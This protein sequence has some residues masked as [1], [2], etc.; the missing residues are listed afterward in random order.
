[1]TTT[2]PL[3]QFLT[4]IWFLPLFLVLPVL[5]ISIIVATRNGEGTRGDT[6]FVAT[7]GEI[8]TP[9]QP[10]KRIVPPPTQLSGS[11]MVDGPF[12][13]SE[14]QDGVVHRLPKWIQQY[15]TWHKQMRSL[16]PGKMVCTHLFCQVIVGSRSG[17]VREKIS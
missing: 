10:T 8:G 13:S 7:R 2:K 12:K 17:Q 11:P 9:R 16:Y 4:C 14:E 1:M 6:T 15:V 3:L 5:V